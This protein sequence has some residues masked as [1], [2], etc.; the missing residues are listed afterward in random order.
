[1]WFCMKLILKILEWCSYYNW[2]RN[3][4]SEIRAIIVQAKPLPW[5]LQN[6]FSVC[7]SDLNGCVLVSAIHEG[8][9]VAFDHPDNGVKYSF[10]LLCRCWEQ[11]L[12]QTKFLPVLLTT[13]QISLS[14]T[15]FWDK[16]SHWTW[17]SPVWLDRLFSNLRHLPSSASQHET[18][19]A[20]YHVWLF[21]NELWR[22]KL[23]SLCLC[24]RHFPCL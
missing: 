6:L 5:N 11:N 2:H 3:R 15:Y 10:K 18:A 4:N 12:G 20:H 13:Q 14:L 7:I 1:M 21:S 24:G 17:S 19:G 9:K 8:Q 22:F 23:W 16:V